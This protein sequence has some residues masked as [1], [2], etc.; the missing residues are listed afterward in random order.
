VEHGRILT[1]DVAAGATL[2]AACFA[3]L[4]PGSTSTD[5]VTVSFKDAA[6]R[7]TAVKR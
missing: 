1:V 6:V 2:Y 5:T 3:V 4:S 7:I